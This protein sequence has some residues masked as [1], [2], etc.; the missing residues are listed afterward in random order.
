MTAWEPIDDMRQRVLASFARQPM[1]STLGVQ[2]VSVEPG[3]V[4]L[5]MSMDSRFTQQHGFLH[6]GTVAAVLDSACGYAAFSLM[7]PD[8]GVLAA[9]YT[10]N[11]LSPAAGQRFRMVAEV[12]R[13]GRTLSVCRAEAF[14]D[15]RSTPIAV[16]QA[17]MAAVY[18]PGI[19][20]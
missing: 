8:A 4:V 15:D 3:R 18:L 1:M 19:E 2:A 16:M 13:S 5:E 14:A 11:L 17:T 6:G 7:P 10:I 12:V 20:H 9:G